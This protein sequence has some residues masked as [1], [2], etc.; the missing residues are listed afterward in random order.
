LLECGTRLAKQGVLIKAEDIVE[1]KLDEI[2]KL[3]QKETIPNISQTLQGAKV[4]E[5]I[6][7]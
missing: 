1:G 4:L 3:L 6:N 5:I 2:R 7:C